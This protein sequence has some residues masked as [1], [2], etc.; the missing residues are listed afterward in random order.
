MSTLTK[1]ALLLL[2]EQFKSVHNVLPSRFLDEDDY[3]AKSNTNKEN[4]EDTE[5]KGNSDKSR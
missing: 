4:K 3:Q 1:E 5:Q 2:K